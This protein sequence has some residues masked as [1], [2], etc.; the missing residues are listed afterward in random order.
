MTTRSIQANSIMIT[1]AGVATEYFR[2]L[3]YY[4]TDR[5]G[6]VIHFRL[7]TALGWFRSG[8]VGVNITNTG[9]VRKDAQKYVNT[10]W[11]VTI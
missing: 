7:A 8:E 3:G 5:T 2:C 11:H 4:R 1:P 10:S 9:L 6:W